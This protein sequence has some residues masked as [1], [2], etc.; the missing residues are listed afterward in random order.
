[1]SNFADPCNPLNPRFN[2][3]KLTNEVYTQEIKIINQVKA[4]DS[5]PQ[6]LCS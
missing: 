4:T 1:M 5:N 3:V 2:Y 6:P